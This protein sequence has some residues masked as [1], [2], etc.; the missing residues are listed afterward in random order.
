MIKIFVNEPLSEG[1]SI[2]IRGSNFHH[3]KVNRVKQNE[4][5]LVGDKNMNEYDAEVIK[6]NKD[7]LEV[8]IISA[9]IPAEPVRD[10]TLYVSLPKGRKFEEIIHKCTQVGVNNFIPFTSQR[11]VK[12]I[13]NKIEKLSERW[14]KKAISGSELSRRRVVPWI[15]NVMTFSKAIEHYC[16]TGYDAG[17][18]FWEE[19]PE[20]AKLSVREIKNKIAVFIGP[21]GGFSKEEIEYACMKGLRITSMGRLVMEVETACIAAS[22]LFLCAE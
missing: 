17:F 5:L 4:R 12:S 14:K 1:T 7:R 22:S 19:D 20:N 11:T 18:I 8:S 16:A 6:I 13:N 2:Y 3:L 15:S 10:V 9:T 21:E